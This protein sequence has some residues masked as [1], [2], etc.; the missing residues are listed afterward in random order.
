MRGRGCLF[1]KLLK[2]SPVDHSLQAAGNVVSSMSSLVHL[3]GLDVRCDVEK[4]RGLADESNC[5]QPRPAS[6]DTACQAVRR[7]S[8]S[9][10]HHVSLLRPSI[11]PISNSIHNPQSLS[12]C[13]TGAEATQLPVALY[14][15]RCSELSVTGLL[16]VRTR[17]LGAPSDGAWACCFDASLSLLRRDRGHP[18]EPSD[19]SR[20]RPATRP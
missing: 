10:H 14:S 13:S 15:Q 19:G 3:L 11:F 7:P 2:R 16:Y 17:C 20:D 9:L 18:G 1:L 8:S 4:R 5:R 12:T 6:Q